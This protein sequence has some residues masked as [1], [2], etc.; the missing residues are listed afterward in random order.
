MGKTARYVL[1]ALAALAGVAVVSLVVSVLPGG[2]GMPGSQS[3]PRTDYW[4]TQGWKT[5]TPE[6]Q[7]M[8][9]AK[10]AEGL[11]DIQKRNLPI[12]SLLVLRNGRIILDAYFYPYDGSA[13]HDLRSVTKSVTTTLVAIAAEQGKLSLDASMNSF[14]PDVSV[15]H[16]DP[17]RD[18]ITVRDLTM[19]AN[20]LDSLG[21]E[22]DEGTL[23]E[24]EASDNFLQ[25]A[26]DRPMASVPGVKFV[27]DSPGMHILS[28]IIQKATGMTELDYAK[29]VL[30]GPL[31]ITDLIWPSDAQG[32]TYG[33]GD[34][35]LHPR[36]AAKIG[37]LWLQGGLWDGKQIVSPDWVKATSRTQIRTGQDDTYSYG[38]WITESSNSTMAEG[39][40]GQEIRVEPNYDAVVVMT[41]AGIDYDNVGHYLAASVVDLE[42]PL[43]ANPEGVAKLE[44]AL[45]QIKQGPAPQSPPPLPEIATKISGRTFLMDPNPAGLKTVRLTFVDAKTARIEATFEGTQPALDELIGL[46][47]TFHFYKGENG[48][49]A[50][51]RGYWSDASTF[52]W[53][54]EL[55][56]AGEGYRYEIRFQG[57][58]ISID[59]IE[60]SHSGSEQFRGT[61][62]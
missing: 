56:S 24:M 47:G 8:D 58:R 35:H 59:G 45:K 2:T 15:S 5:S 4:P 9:S 32:H 29:Q 43:P 25:F 26:L 49:P 27:Y 18:A 48:L 11:L 61:L 23:N 20:G 41:G 17:R 51:G 44:A 54:R 3:P 55:V 28:G 10:L 30:F 13:V 6:E 14:F 19:M 57:D 33:W 38:W 50:A 42:K 37:F 1:W 12:H 39:R 53:E 46:D 21:F 7:G 40:G 31:G 16:P 34:L 52:T 60:R 36:D 62:Q 22:Q